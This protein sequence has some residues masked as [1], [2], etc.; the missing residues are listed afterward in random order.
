MLPIDTG[1][2]GSLSGAE[3]LA[4]V[5]G[6]ER[7]RAAAPTETPLGEWEV[8]RLHDIDAGMPGAVDLSTSRM[9]RAWGVMVCVSYGVGGVWYM[10]VRGGGRLCER[11]RGGRFC[12]QEG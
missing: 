2:C 1:S 7:E 5:A 12:L 8:L 11:S 6:A 3:L 4:A 9:V 10:W